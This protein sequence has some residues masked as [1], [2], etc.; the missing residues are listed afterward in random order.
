MDHCFVPEIS[1]F[2]LA[3]GTL[4]GGKSHEELKEHLSYWTEALNGHAAGSSMDG[5]V[6]GGLV[7][8]WGGPRSG[9]MHGVGRS[10]HGDV[11]G[12]RV[13]HG[14]GVIHGWRGPFGG[15]CP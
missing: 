14:V 2:V 5:K 10:I 7:H 4:R 1:L 15:G 8:Q 12:V 6:H 11:Q 9:F 13:V 3:F